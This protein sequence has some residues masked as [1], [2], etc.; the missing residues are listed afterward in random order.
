VAAIGA[1]WVITIRG[2]GHYRLM[3]A[4]LIGLYRFAPIGFHQP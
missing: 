3:L 1:G 4:A 2:V